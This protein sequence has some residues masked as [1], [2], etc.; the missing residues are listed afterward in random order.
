MTNNQLIE[1]IVTKECERYALEDSG[2]V[3]DR[4]AVARELSCERN[5]FLP[6]GCSLE[7]FREWKEHLL[8]D[9][10]SR[11][12]FAKFFR[13]KAEKHCMFR[14]VRRLSQNALSAIQRVYVVVV[15][16]SLL[17]GNWRRFVSR[18]CALCFL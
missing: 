12:G 6:N 14:M 1:E 16:Y 9:W 2:F 5:A 4:R 7:E 17:P 15:Y 3:T 11:K 18:V 8:N 13:R 10:Y